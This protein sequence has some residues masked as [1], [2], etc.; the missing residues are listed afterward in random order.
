MFLFQR[1]EIHAAKLRVL[2]KFAFF[3]LHKD[4][5]GFRGSVRTGDRTGKDPPDLPVMKSGWVFIG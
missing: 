2:V 1:L 4:I 5:T 3:T